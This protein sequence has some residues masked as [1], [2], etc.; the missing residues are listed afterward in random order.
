VLYGKQKNQ[1]ATN[2]AEAEIA[3]VR[4]SRG[5]PSFK[6][7]GL[8]DALKGGTKM[9]HLRRTAREVCST[10]RARRERLG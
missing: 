7:K 2:M 9:G 6:N 4:G 3:I 5:G 1:G 8:M 10:R